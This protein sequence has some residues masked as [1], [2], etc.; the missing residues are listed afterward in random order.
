[1]ANDQPGESIQEQ[2][3]QLLSG[4]M[5]LATQNN[6]EVKTSAILKTLRKA[7]TSALE[8]FGKLGTF[9]TGETPV[10]T[11][12]AGLQQVCPNLTNSDTLLTLLGDAADYMRKNPNLADTVSA[13]KAFF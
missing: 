11:S 1:M 7:P 12:L 5:S 3:E 8:E 4:L 6:G 13:I 10:P 2:V 9:L